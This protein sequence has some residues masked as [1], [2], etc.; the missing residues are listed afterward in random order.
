[1]FQ[2]LWWLYVLWPLGC[3][4][5]LARTRLLGGVVGAALVGQAVVL[6]GLEYEWWSLLAAAELTVA[7]P[8][9]SLLAILV[10][11]LAERR[12]RGRRPEPAASHRVGGA[13]VALACHAIVG[14]VIAAAY[15]LYLSGFAYYPSLAELPLPSGLAVQRD[16]GTA[17]G[18]A[19][20]DCTREISIGSTSGL[21]PAAV[22]ACLRDGLNA[23]G[24]T[25]GPSG[26]LQHP[27]GWL[28][29]KR[30]V[31]VFITESP[32]GASVELVGPEYFGES[33]TP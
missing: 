9:G 16:S 17:G 27:H 6:I 8:F 25:A 3:W 5:A 13:T 2:I 19:S 1:M 21:P 28:L 11:V 24:W 32:R 12:L 22:A 31:R 30:V 18:C 23:A 20:H 14:V 4:A 10:G 15:P 26:S 29:D 33:A 7:Y